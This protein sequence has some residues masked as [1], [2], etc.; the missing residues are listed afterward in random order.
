MSLR[1]SLT[2]LYSP[3]SK[4][5]NP[6]LRP[7]AASQMHAIKPQGSKGGGYLLPKASDISSLGSDSPLSLR[8]LC[9]ELPPHRAEPEGIPDCLP[10]RALHP[11]TLLLWLGLANAPAMNLDSFSL[12]RS[13]FISFFSFFCFCSQFVI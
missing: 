3:E 8:A 13:S 12:T 10:L 9:R 7:Q 5:L 2:L 4:D 11:G 6:E 1:G